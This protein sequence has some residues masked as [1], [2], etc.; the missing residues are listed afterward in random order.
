MR[1]KM[2]RNFGLMPKIGKSTE[3]PLSVCAV[4]DVVTW[5]ELNIV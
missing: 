5:A 1:K 4:A 3:V 2:L